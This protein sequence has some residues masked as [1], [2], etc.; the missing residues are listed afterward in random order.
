MPKPTAARRIRTLALLT[1][2]CSLLVP[3]IAEAK[4][5][6]AYYTI[7]GP[8]LPSSVEFSVDLQGR[9]PFDPEMALST[10]PGFHPQDVS[11]HQSF[12]IRAY[13]ESGAKHALSHMY[14]FPQADGTAYIYFAGSMVDPL[15]FDNVAGKWFY[16]RPAFV[17]AVELVTRGACLTNGWSSPSISSRR[18]C[19]W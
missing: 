16:A 12:L 6:I 4:G 3:A 11:L 7:Q 10:P 9:I 19:W 14:Y 5:A 1:A 13:M 18:I 17:E 15:V 8:G 2:A